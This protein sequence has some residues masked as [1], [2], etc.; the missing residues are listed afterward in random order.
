[1]THDKA[2][3]IPFVSRWGLNKEWR[4]EWNEGGEKESPNL[5][6]II[7]HHFEILVFEVKNIDFIIYIG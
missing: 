1:M 2:L 4:K 3:S 7:E 6:N 5:M